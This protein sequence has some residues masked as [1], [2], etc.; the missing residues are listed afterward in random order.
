MKMSTDLG[1]CEWQHHCPAPDTL[2]WPLFLLECVQ[3]YL[4]IF[5]L[6]NKEITCSSPLPSAGPE[7]MSHQGAMD[8]WS[9]PSSPSCIHS[10]LAIEVAPG[11][12]PLLLQR[13]PIV[14]SLLTFPPFW[15]LPFQLLICLITS[16][17]DTHK[18]TE[19]VTDGTLRWMDVIGAELSTHLSQSHFNFHFKSP[20]GLLAM[21]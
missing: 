20:C 14:I 21:S 10:V 11:V 9:L 1:I 19:H 4:C 16:I 13:H 5:F 12:Q 6:L 2:N 15:E 17:A 18:K 3:D 7:R 8:S